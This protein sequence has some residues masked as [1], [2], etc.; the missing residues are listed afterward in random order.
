MG[1]WTL[2]STANLLSQRTKNTFSVWED[3]NVMGRIDLI[4]YSRNTFGVPYHV[5]HRARL[6]ELIAKKGP[7]NL[8]SE[9]LLR[10]K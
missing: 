6:H 5:V 10:G 4:P 8:L 1:A 3:G 9:A 2:Y 7:E